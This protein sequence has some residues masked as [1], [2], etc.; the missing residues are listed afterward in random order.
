MKLKE[1]LGNI[2]KTST[3]ENLI[4][5][6]QIGKAADLEQLWKDIIEPNLPNKETVI[7]WHEVLKD[8]IRQEDAKF[9]IRRFGSRTKKE[10]SSV[11]RR[12]FLNKVFVGKKELFSTFY[13]DN[14][15]PAYF[16]SMAKD[17]YAPADCNE[18]KSLIDNF[19]FPC[20]YF[21]TDAEKEL[22]AFK[23]GQNPEISTKGYKIAH[24]FSA[25]EGYSEEAGYVKI[26]DFCNNVFP[27]GERKE[28]QVNVSPSGVHFRPIQLYSEAEAQTIKKFA[29]AHFIRTVHPLNFFLVPNKSNTR[30]KESG[31]LKTN[32]YYK[33]H[34]GK[35]KN[36]I[37]EYSKLIEYV[38]A[39][40]KDIYKDTNV[41]QE[42]LDLIF[43][44][45]NCIDP[46]ADNVQIDAEYAIGI[47]QKKI[48]NATISSK[49][50]SDTAKN[51]DDVYNGS[52]KVP[53]IG[54]SALSDNAAED[55]SEFEVY[56]SRNG[57]GTPSGYTSKIKAVMKEVD[58]DSVPELNERIDEA[59]DYCDKKVKEARI[60]GDGKTAKKYSD[61]RAIL[62]K[63]KKYLEESTQIT[64]IK[65]E[66][67]HSIY[68]HYKKG[69]SSFRPVDEHVVE[70]IIEND[71][72]TVFYNVGFASGKV[73]TKKISGK[74]MNE[75]L[76]LMNDAYVTKTL[77]KSDTAIRAEHGT[78]LSYDYDYRCYLERNCSSLF[79][80]DALN[81]RYAHLIDRIIN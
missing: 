77:E 8:Y 12:G 74:D 51:S 46:K 31:I 17:G 43:P 63:Y 75:L 57:V 23:K 19:E 29:I 66:G 35:A 61:F 28:W 53:F 64:S 13:V 56:A 20:G 50:I 62:K 45:G 18:F 10:D 69:W 37:G 54:G 73:I 76:G 38:A 40:I 65:G 2:K 16:Y 70:Y 26:A 4:S 33:D 6:P 15:F 44:I 81:M 1:K 9:S 55:F 59:I 42:F 58:I 3:L 72:I 52:K 14:G 68:I 47:W 30:D 78:I 36:E 67:A 27:R 41:Y 34:N 11:L 32:I 7:K 80:D 24:I 39:K 60:G 48:N 21:Q 79:T 5:Y 49:A 71:E 25:G 22:A